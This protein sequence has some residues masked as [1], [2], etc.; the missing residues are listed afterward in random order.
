MENIFCVII[1]V[2]FF[3]NSA[4]IKL[5]K[6]RQYETGKHNK[7]NKEIDNYYN[8]DSRNACKFC[9][10]RDLNVEH[11]IILSSSL[12]NITNMFRT[13]HKCCIHL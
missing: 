13:L 1:H 12:A 6:N 2:F 3:Q 9:P 4:N 10:Q 5:L 11:F 8:L 7:V